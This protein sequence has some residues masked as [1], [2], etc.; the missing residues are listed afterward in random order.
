MVFDIVRVIGQV[1]ITMH[2]AILRTRAKIIVIN[3]SISSMRCGMAVLRWLEKIGLSS[4]EESPKNKVRSKGNAN[5]DDADN[6]GGRNRNVGDMDNNYGRHSS[7]SV[8]DMGNNDYACTDNNCIRNM[9]DSRSKL[10]YV[11]IS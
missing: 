3:A 9:A 4:T 8:C 7:H 5:S 10:Y 11:C 2:I 6:D 1:G